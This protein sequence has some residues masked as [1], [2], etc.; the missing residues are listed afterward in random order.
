[1]TDQ[2]Q[3]EIRIDELAVSG[4]QREEQDAEGD[5]HDE[6]RCSNDWADWL[7]LQASRKEDLFEQ[8]QRTSC[9]FVSAI[10]RLADLELTDKTHHGSG[11]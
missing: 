7:L 10:D 11:K 8:G 4:D 2:W 6:V 1:M 3:C 9:R 5:Q